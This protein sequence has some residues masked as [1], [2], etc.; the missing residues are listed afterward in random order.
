MLPLIS[1]HW[2]APLISGVVI[3]PP[4]RTQTI[5]IAT[6][7][8]VLC[9]VGTLSVFFMG[10]ILDEERSYPSYSVEGTSDGSTV[11]G[12]ATCHDTGESSRQTVLEFRYALS[13]DRGTI[14]L[15]SHLILEGGTPVGIY[16]NTGTSET[17]GRHVT[18]W[19]DPEGSFTYH[20]ADDGS[21]LAID[22]SEGSVVARAVADQP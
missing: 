13:G 6:V 8:V 22:I 1:A 10:N 16:E 9:V 7:V 15:T 2:T 19:K 12:T 11:T 4:M 3:S 17:L 5:A 14:E 21:V 18:L 20:V